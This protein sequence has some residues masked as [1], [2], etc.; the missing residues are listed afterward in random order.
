VT[1]RHPKFQVP[2]EKKHIHTLRCG[3]LLSYMYMGVYLVL[4]GRVCDLLFSSIAMSKSLF[5]KEP[6]FVWLLRYII[7]ELQL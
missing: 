5:D 2:P 1:C 6:Y 7:F 3:L 4:C